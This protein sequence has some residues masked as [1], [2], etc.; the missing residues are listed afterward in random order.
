[1]HRTII[2]LLALSA[3]TV[4]AASTASASCTVNDLVG[5]WAVYITPA[6]SLTQLAT[7]PPA[8][9]MRCQFDGP[10]IIAEN[11]VGFASY[12]CTSAQGA[13]Q[14]TGFTLKL[15]DAP[16]CQVDSRINYTG[17]RVA[18]NV[19]STGTLNQT[20]NIIMGG[21]TQFTGVGFYY[22]VS[23]VRTD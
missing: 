10:S 14:M 6:A 23:M 2:R 15:S 16:H 17:P 21:T 9:P 1:M 13:V 4:A 20:K 22:V 3:A 8:F 12:T 7:H 18:D 5:E 11:E 19:P